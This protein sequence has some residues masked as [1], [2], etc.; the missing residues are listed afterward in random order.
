V[1]I[2]AWCDPGGWPLDI[3]SKYRIFQFHGIDV[4]GNSF[5][6]KGEK[7]ANTKYKA[8]NLIDNTPYPDNTFETVY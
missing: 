6:K 3:A 2:Y 7:P 4:F 1:V 5:P 8:G